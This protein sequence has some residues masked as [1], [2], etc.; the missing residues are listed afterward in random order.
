MMKI[1]VDTNIL[2]SSLLSERASQRKILLSK[3][4]ATYAPNYVFVELFNYKEKIIQNAKAPET[5]VYEYLTT[6]LGHLHFVHPELIS[7]ENRHAAYLLCHDIDPDD[8]PLVALTLQLTA[9][10]WTGDNALKVG[11]LNK[12]FDKFF[13]AH[14]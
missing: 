14:S 6:I 11:L 2:F 8:I 10:L 4:H 9:L 7:K 13:D 1:V 5:E 3:H 12:G